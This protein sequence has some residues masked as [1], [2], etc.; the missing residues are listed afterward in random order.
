[1]GVRGRLSYLGGPLGVLAL[2][3]VLAVLLFSRAWAN[4]SAAWAGVDTDPNL[5]IWYLGWT[6]HQLSSLQSPFFTTD[7][8]FP[9]GTNLMWNTSIVLPALVLWPVTAAFGPIVAYNVMVTAAVALSAWCAYLAVR[10]LVPSNLAA[11]WAGLLYGFSPY[12]THQSLGHP[13]MTLAM[14]PPLVLLMLHELLVR[15]RGGAVVMGALLGVASAL[16]LLTGEEILAGTVL[17]AVAGVALLAYFHRH[18]ID[19]Q[20]RRVLQASGAA[21]VC[22][23]V[24]AAY[25]LAFQFLGP[26]RVFG[27]L[28][29]P[30]VIVSDLLGF[31]VPPETMAFSS[32]GSVALTDHFTAAP[33]ENGAYLGIPLM[34][35]FAVAAVARR[36]SP[37]VRWAA[38]LTVVAAVLSLGPR[39]HIAGVDTRVPLPW[40]PLGHLPLLE[41]LLPSRLMLFA[42]LG[43]GIVV[44]D[45]AAA[46]IRA[47]GRRRA[48]ALAALC[49]ASL[50]LVPKLPYTTT[51]ARVPSFFQAG[52]GAEQLPPGRVVLVTPYANDGS[53]HAMLWQAVAGYRFKM[54]EGDA[55]VPGPTLGPPPSPLQTTLTRLD[56]GRSVSRS[57]ADLARTRAELSQARVQSVVAGPSP[58]HD[59]IVRYLTL[60]LGRP[61][62]Y[63]GGVDVWW[64]V[65]AAPTTL[66]PA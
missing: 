18:Q 53:S 48:A 21:A 43:A 35:L 28:Q 13:H 61:P 25:P 16:Q 23:A 51:E 38:P 22:F 56:A 41:N 15:R 33:G 44:A 50:P 12:M 34:V 42:F 32:S 31:L 11:G 6:P 66:Q 14:F 1:V 30:N 54:P 52:G 7:L 45:L 27:L 10:R 29:P 5:F 40:L 63:S 3:I 4:P 62:A 24:L 59:R 8:L 19:G 60:V 9:A 39:L 26:R 37:I 57:E 36:R 20:D 49:V 55:F 17:A 64:D 65:P 47:G 46:G 58:G 2:F